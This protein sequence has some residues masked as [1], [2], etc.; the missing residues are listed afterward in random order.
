MF[1][2]I[3]LKITQ[4]I[5]PE[6]FG[7]SKNMKRKR[8][9]ALENGMPFFKKTFNTKKNTKARNN[10]YLDRENNIRTSSH[11]ARERS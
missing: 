7:L 6:W 10:N 5:M 11:K 9:Y 3:C 1:R 8:S 4:K 2:Q